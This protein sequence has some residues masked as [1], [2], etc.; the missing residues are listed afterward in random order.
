[1]MDPELQQLALEGLVSFDGQVMFPDEYLEHWADIYCANN[2]HARGVPFE[3]YLQH[4]AEYLA[5]AIFGTTPPLP[6]GLDHFPLLPAQR[7]VAWYLAQQARM[8]PDIEVI[9]AS[10]TAD[11]ECRLAGDGY[12]EPLRHHSYEV[13]RTRSRRVHGL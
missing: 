8:A 4:P 12:Q 7:D 2:L 9:E 11:A 13:S 6:P 10:L 1:M 3:L 5:A